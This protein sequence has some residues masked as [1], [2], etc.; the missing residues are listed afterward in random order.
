VQLAQRS[1]VLDG[2]LGRELPAP[3]PVPT[4]SLRE[5]LLDAHDA[6]RAQSGS[7]R[8]RGTTPSRSFVSIRRSFHVMELPFEAWNCGA[9]LDARRSQ[10][11]ARTEA[12]RRADPARFPSR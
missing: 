9:P 12:E 5:P 3:L 7:R 10:E 6:A 1:G 8:R 4:F 11:I 2:D